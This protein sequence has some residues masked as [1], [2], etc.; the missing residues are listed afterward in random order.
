[1]TNRSSVFNNIP[2]HLVGQFPNKANPHS[3]TAKDE[4]LE[5]IALN[6]FS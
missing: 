1:M 6:I 4:T 3:I 2:P 5:V